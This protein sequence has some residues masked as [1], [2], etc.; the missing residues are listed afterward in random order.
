[1]LRA[2][3]GALEQYDEDAKPERSGARS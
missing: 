2:A 3:L 1:M